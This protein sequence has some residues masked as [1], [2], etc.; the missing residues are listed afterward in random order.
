MEEEQCELR[1]LRKNSENIRERFL[2]GEDR[3]GPI[4]KKKNRG[5]E[6]RGKQRENWGAKRAVLCAVYAGERDAGER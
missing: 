3:G 6:G 1:I 4:G 5:A 2:V